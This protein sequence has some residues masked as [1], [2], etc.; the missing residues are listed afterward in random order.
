MLIDVL[1]FVYVW[2]AKG[3]E[4][5]IYLRPR[6]RTIGQSTNHRW[7]PSIATP[8]PSLTLE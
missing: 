4:P 7:G 8:R 6:L 5:N 1:E 2:G 3:V